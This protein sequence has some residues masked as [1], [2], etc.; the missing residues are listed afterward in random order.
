MERGG[1]E[2]SQPAQRGFGTTLLESALAVDGGNTPEIVL[3][4]WRFDYRSMR[5]AVAF[6]GPSSE[7]FSSP[8]RLRHRSSNPE[9]DIFNGMPSD[10]KDFTR[11][12]NQSSFPLHLFSVAIARVPV[13]QAS[14]EP[15]L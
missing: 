3:R 10:T 8:R 11:A 2:V 5:A 9:P 14:R 13:A 1:P 12:A 7:S 6:R 15:H 4:C